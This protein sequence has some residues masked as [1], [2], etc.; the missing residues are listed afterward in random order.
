QLRTDR[1]VD[2][3]AGALDGVAFLD[4]AVAAEDDDADIVGFEVQR[5]AANAAGELDHLAG[6][7]IVE[8][9]DAG[10]AVTDGQNLTDFG[11]LGFLAE[12]LDLVFQNCGNFRGADI[13]QPTSFSASLS[14]ASLV[15]SDVSIWRE[16][17]LTIRPP[18]I[19]GSTVTESETSLPA[20]SLSAALSSVCW[21]AESSCAEVTSAETSPRARAAISRKARIM[22][23][24]ANRRRFCATT[25]RKLP[26]SPPI[27]ALS[28]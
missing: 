25:R 13:H 6:L 2:D 14:E 7:D 27:F 12:I 4:V 10:D 1:N 23:G 21:A 28:T 5:H 24:T 19:E 22:P 3:R 17:S 8:A 9:V 20:T 15:L 18:R 16:P 26:V 11:N